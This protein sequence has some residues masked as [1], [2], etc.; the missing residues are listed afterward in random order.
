MVLYEAMASA[1]IH[2]LIIV[3]TP[4]L[5]P[6]F[7]NSCRA[8]IISPNKALVLKLCLRL[9]FLGKSAKKNIANIIY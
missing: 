8:G 7:P 3:T 9:C 1:V 4:S 6:L 5:P 2:H